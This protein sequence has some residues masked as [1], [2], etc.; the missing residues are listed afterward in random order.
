[1]QCALMAYSAANRTRQCQWALGR[2]GPTLTMVSATASARVTTLGAATTNR[3][4]FYSPSSNRL[5]DN[6]WQNGAL[7][8]G[9]TIMML[10]AT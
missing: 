10:R 1:M 9:I 6:I 4:Q 7:L 5:F 2:E 3:T 8:Q